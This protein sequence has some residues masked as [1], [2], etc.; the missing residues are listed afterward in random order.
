MDNCGTCRLVYNTNVRRDYG[1]GNDKIS[2]TLIES[3]YIDLGVVTDISE[4][5]HKSTSSTPRV[6]MGAENTF[7]ME[8]GSSLTLSVKFERVCPEIPNDNARNS[9]LIENTGELTKDPYE[10]IDLSD[11]DADT[12]S[13]VLR[14]NGSRRWSNSKWYSEIT[15][16][17]DRWQ[18][19][20]DGFK[21]L[22]IPDQNG[23]DDDNPYIPAYNYVN[24]YVK[25]LSLNYK[26]GDP[27]VIYGTLEF[28]VGTMYLNTDSAN[29]LPEDTPDAN[30]N[31]DVT[32]FISPSTPCMTLFLDMQG[33]TSSA[34]LYSVGT[35]QSEMSYIDS[36][37]DFTLEGGPNSP[38]ECITFTTA[39][40]A[41]RNNVDSS[42]NP[43][44][45]QKGSVVRLKLFSEGDTEQKTIQ[46]TVQTIQTRRMT[47]SD[48][49]YTICAYS[50]EICLRDL[51]LATGISN[52]SPKDIIDKI[53]K[54]TYGRK[55]SDDE[56]YLKTNVVS[57]GPLISV[58][59]GMNLWTLTKLCAELLHAKVFFAQGHMY[60]IDYPVLDYATEYTDSVLANAKDVRLNAGRLRQHSSGTTE[61]KSSNMANS[62][63]NYCLL[64]LDISSLPSDE[65]EY[66][67]RD[68]MDLYGTFAYDADVD[69]HVTLG[70]DG[71]T[72][73][74]RYVLDYFAYPQT[75]LE[76]TLKE[77]FA[78]DNARR[79]EMV[80]PPATY[81]SS[82]TDELMGFSINARPKTKFVDSAG[83]ADPPKYDF[84]Q[85]LRTATLMMSQYRCNL[86]SCQTTYVF[87]EINESSLAQT[88]NA[89]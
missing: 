7:V 62:M 80:Y 14:M 54:G 11:D 59:S 50:P 36:S 35:G 19:R 4:S 48:K 20:T 12:L 28:H 58:K 6:S 57:N 27:Q 42:Y 3:S 25:N 41:L 44:T 16:A 66:C 65:K 88:L 78:K 69:S 2:K 26:A 79:W 24:G 38:F 29:G 39:R 49:R 81:A 67:R 21:F 74:R 86:L 83:T 18:V 77:I 87:G 45:P 5:F 89:I 82:L 8:T 68:S 72:A 30:L 55:L 34:Q 64:G 63:Y 70:A 71:Y 53:I 31:P 76:F 51:T 52:E 10:S 17:I 84:A 46:Y 23:S 15:A 47:S 61:E 1:D 56:D 40:N 22:Y 37:N 85:E 13:R 75:P 73:L 32:A 60:L 43:I 9:L 33:G